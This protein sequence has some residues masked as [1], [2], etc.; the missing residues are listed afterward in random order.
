MIY[1]LIFALGALIYVALELI[2]RGRSH[3]TMALAGGVCALLLFGLYRRFF[4]LPL[5]VLCLM[6]GLVITAVEFITGFIVN[7]TMDWKVW[8]YSNQSGNLYGQVCPAYSLMWVLLSAP[9][10]LLLD[11]VYTLTSA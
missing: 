8:D 1:P 2:W 6:G 4:E 10:Y 5:P 7:L 3:W 9:A 11:F